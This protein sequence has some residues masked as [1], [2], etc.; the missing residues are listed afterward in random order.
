MNPDNKIT[1]I[2]TYKKN[3]SIETLIKN[4]IHI[5]YEAFSNNQVTPKKSL[6]LNHDLINKK[7]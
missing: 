5:E 2:R 6:P 1:I 7:S 3:C 4:I